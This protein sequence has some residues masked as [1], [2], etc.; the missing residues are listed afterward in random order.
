MEDRLFKIGGKKMKIFHARLLAKY[1]GGIKS[2]FNFSMDLIQI[3]IDV[4]ALGCKPYVHTK[5]CHKSFV[6]YFKSKPQHNNL[7]KD[8]GFLML[9]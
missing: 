8:K 4:V 2:D 9:S 1:L 6:D 3:I 5:L 7:K